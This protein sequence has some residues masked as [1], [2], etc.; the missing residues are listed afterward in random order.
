MALGEAFI[1]VRADLKPFSRDVEKGVKEILR[2]VE[3]RLAADSQTGASIRET[4]RR[5]ASDGISRGLEEGFDRG[6]KRGTKR[7]LS[8]GQKFFAALADFADDGLS[9]IP[10]KVKAGILIGVLAA[11]VAAAPLIGGVIS[12][13]IISGVALGVAG[14]GIALASQFKVVE[15]QFTGLG[16]NILDGLRDASSVFIQPLLE[17]AAALN[18]Q[19]EAVRGTIKR[20]F[21]Q[22]ARDVA[23][24]TLALGGFVT[25]LLPGIEVATRR[26][27]PLIEAL[28]VALPKLGRDISEAFAIISS[29]SPEAVVALRDILNVVG[30]MIINFANLVRGLTEIYYWMRLISE[31][32]TGDFVQAVA[33]IAEREQSAALASG[34]L[35]A[36]L[37]GTNTALGETANQAYA[38]RNAISDL[39]NEQLRGINATIDYEQAIDDLAASL[40][41]GNRDFRVTEEAGRTNLRLVEQAITASA[42][43]RD[44]ALL[45]AQVTGESVATINAA[46]QAEINT[47]ENI[48]GKNIQQDETLKT[49]FT[50][51]RN[52]P[53]GVA[54]PVS[55]P[56]AAESTARVNALRI[57]FERLTG[58]VKGYIRARG[59]TPPTGMSATVA[60]GF[61]NGAIIDSPTVGLV[62]E[63]GYKEAIIPDPA[64]MPDRAM[65]LS[66][67][68]GLTQMIAD[69]LGAGQTIVNVFI[70][71]QRLEEIADY[72]IAVNNNMQAQSLA[73][74]PRPA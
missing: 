69:A 62:G 11:G 67:R 2:A 40:R 49:L 4:M 24:L 10:A 1:N 55:T 56:G 17:S 73:Y 43:Q 3:K 74:G 65:E 61:A 18:T 46:Y 27:R 35:S 63:A 44:E 7:A 70:G 12:A 34:Q 33:L 23:P 41:E 53:K 15:D 5:Q 68:F 51:A 28:A 31:L 21:G 9:A 13:A 30:I 8:T 25:N 39:I 72:R 57:A 54:I 16:R 20:I 52:A 59:N 64:V 45:R 22:A 14:A 47:I 50:T 48:I 19:F 60:P 37:Q 26:A 66:N 58:Q 32:A 29:G 42:K 38:A 6:A 71:Q 36:G